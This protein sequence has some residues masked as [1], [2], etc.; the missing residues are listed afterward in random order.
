MKSLHLIASMD[1]SS[2][3]VCQAL[4]NSIPELARLGCESEV[5]C[6]DD[7]GETRKSNDPFPVHQLG[8]GRGP[9]ALSLTL[10]PWMQSQLPEFDVVILHGLWLYPSY[11]VRKVTQNLRHA[12]SVRCPRFFVMPHGMLDPWF[13]RDPSRR[14]KAIRN[15]LVWMTVERYTI[16]RADGLLFTCQRE[17]ELARE[18]FRPYQPRVE[19]VV[20]L[21]VPTPPSQTQAMKAKFRTKVPGLGERPYLLFL[22]RIH[23]KKGVDLLIDAYLDLNAREP[24]SHNSRPN[25]GQREAVIVPDL[26]IAGPTD[27]DFGETMI[28]RADGHTSIHFPG[29]LSGDTKWG[30]FYGCDAFVLPSHQE[31]FGIAVVEALACGKPVL[32]SDQVN[33]YR[34]IEDAGGGLVRPDTLMGAANLLRDFS[35]L[36]AEERVKM[37]IAAEHCFQKYFSIHQGAAKML[38]AI[39]SN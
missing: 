28:R 30:A 39:K 38:Q 21:G 23:P 14:L 22:S 18:T 13:Q 16:E 1:P 12:D 9:W 31:N 37:S 7:P 32:I 5:V 3:G 24:S 4:R 27:S 11:A 34:E 20:G 15:W 33:I 6:L 8:R 17:L 2:G 29:M 19:T 26:V 25:I 10:A 36:S 35:R